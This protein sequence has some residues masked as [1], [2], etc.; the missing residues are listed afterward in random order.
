MQTKPPMNE[1]R[2]SSPHQ[3]LLQKRLLQKRLLQKRILQRGGDGLSD[4]ELLAVCMG[5]GN[6]FMDV[7][8]LARGLIERFDGL[9]NLIDA[10]AARLLLEPGLGPARVAQLKAAVLLAERRAEERLRDAPLLTSAE[11]V[12][13]YLRL[14][15]ARARREVFFGLFLDS[16]HHLIA[17]ESLFLGTVDRASVHPRALLQR[18]LQLNAAAVILAHNHPSGIAEPSVSDVDLTRDLVALLAKIDVSLLDH[19]VVGR[20]VEVSFAERGWL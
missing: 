11:A 15:L 7:F 8:G 18:A 20:G 12:R 6:R 2:R 17:C 3:R 19:L 16:R 14:K 13:R 5:S 9:A 10:D 4:A 1:V